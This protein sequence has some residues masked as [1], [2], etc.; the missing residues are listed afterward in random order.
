MII[1]A[2]WGLATLL[3]LACPALAGECRLALVLALDVS[4]SV[5]EVEDRFQREGLARALLGPEVVRAFLAGDPVAL[6][7]FTWAGEN[8]QVALLPGWQLIRS[9]EDLARV[10]AVI[11]AT[12]PVRLGGS[13]RPMAT[14][15][16]DALDYAAE[17]LSRAPP[18][19]ARTVDVAG[20][21][22]SNYGIAPQAIYSRGLLDGVTVNALVIGGAQGHGA[23]RADDEDAALVAWFEADVLH[24]PGAFWILANGYEDYERAMWAKLLRELQ[25]PMVS[26][27]PMTDEGA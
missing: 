5:N 17:A 23:P 21:G 1:P 15:V 22:T 13:L 18:C 14:A 10:G 19:Q 16:G 12:E 8:S 11:A 7:A 24:G 20:D 4:G 9:E 25:I 2:V 27:L 3:G 26:G 6:Y